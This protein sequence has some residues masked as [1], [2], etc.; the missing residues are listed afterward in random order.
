M[1][2]FNKLYVFY[3]ASNSIY[4]NSSFWYIIPNKS[5]LIVYFLRNV[6]SITTFWVQEVTLVFEKFDEVLL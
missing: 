2:Y 3:V 1:R 5:I 6:K 4:Y